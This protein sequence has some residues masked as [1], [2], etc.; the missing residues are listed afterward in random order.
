[1]DIETMHRSET[2]VLKLEGLCTIDHAQELKELLMTALK[3]NAW[4]TADL[5]GVTEVD[6]SCL[7]LL[8]AAHRAFLAENKELAIHDKRSGAFRRLVREAGF[9][10]TLGCHNDPMKSC[11][12]KG[13]LEQ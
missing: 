10:R 4:V 5:Q 6:L 13:G 11:L 9:E 12:W 1:M 7:Q 3:E 2:R 8:C